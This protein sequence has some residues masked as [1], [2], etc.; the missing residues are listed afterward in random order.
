MFIGLSEFGILWA[1]LVSYES[2]VC[3]L[4]YSSNLQDAE[5]VLLESIRKLV[6]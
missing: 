1:D 5:K 4:M 2:T 3:S 6:K